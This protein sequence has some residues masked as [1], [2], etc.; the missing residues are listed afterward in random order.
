MLPSSIRASVSPDTIDRVGRLFNNTLDDVLNELLQNAR[1]ASATRVE[2]TLTRGD[3]VILSISDDG[4]GIADPE[5]VL[6]LGRSDWGD[7][8][9]AREDPAGMGMFSLAGHSVTITS[10]HA[11][12]S[13]AWSAEIPADAWDGSQAIPLYE[14]DHPIGTTID[15]QIPADWD[16]HLDR[17]AASAAFHYPLPVTFNGTDC[18]RKDWLAEAVHIARW[19]GCRIGVFEGSL[20][21]LNATLN[22]HGLTIPCKLPTVSEIRGGG[23]YYVRVDIIDAPALQLVLPARKEAV[24]NAA[25]RELRDAAE[26]T[27]Y[28]AIAI[29]G[30]HCLA[31]KEWSRAAKIGVNLLE[32]EAQLISWF[33]S[34]ADWDTCYGQAKLIDAANAIVVEEGEPPVEQCVARAL[35]SSPLRGQMVDPQP[36][37]AGYSWYDALAQ[38]GNFRFEIEHDGGCFTLTDGSTVPPLAGDVKASTITLRADLKD[39]GKLYPISAETDIVLASDPDFISNL[40]ELRII[41]LS[42]LPVDDLVDLLD[43]GYFCPSDDVASDS[44]DTQHRRFE[45]DARD[46]A[47]KLLR[48]PDEAICDQF[49]CLVRDNRWIVPTGS[50]LAITRADDDITVTLTRESA[51]VS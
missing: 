8:V 1:R 37:F 46:R 36:D 40:D 34:S 22:F 43:A 29:K 28:E 2:I 48:G 32:A 35:K 11:A 15:I 5:S 41:Y 45:A 25:L 14:A 33:P 31:F 23:A 21:H 51:S 24:E 39:R 44:W 3:R 27:I 6:T 38:L 42:T 9:S 30:R 18:P 19:N 26:R 47:I 7:D 13:L 49:R 20:R 16:D 10:R 50:R 12:H 4:Q 17:L